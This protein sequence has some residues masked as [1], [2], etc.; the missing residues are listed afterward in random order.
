[1]PVAQSVEHRVVVLMMTIVGGSNPTVSSLVDPVSELKSCLRS[2]V[3][4]GCLRR[5]A[6]TGL[7]LQ[8]MGPHLMHTG[9]KQLGSLMK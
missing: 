9:K 2:E 6:P 5:C 1:M 7:T 3:P 4:G 8:H